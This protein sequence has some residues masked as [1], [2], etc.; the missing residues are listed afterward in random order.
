[1]LILAI[2]FLAACN[3][4]T[5]DNAAP[6]ES[7]IDESEI[8]SAHS[9]SE[10]IEESKQGNPYLTTEE[11]LEE[12]VNQLDTNLPIWAPATMKIPEENHLSAKTNTTNDSYE[13][14]LYALIEPIPI[15]NEALG[16]QDSFI[17]FGVAEYESKEAAIEYIQSEQDGYL[18]FEGESEEINLGY[19]ITGH[20]QAGTGHAGIRWSIGNWK[21]SSVANGDRIKEAEPIAKEVVEVLE[22][23]TLPAPD[24][25]GTVFINQ[26][27]EEDTLT[28]V[29]WQVGSHV[30][31][32]YSDSLTPDQVLETVAKIGKW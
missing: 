19:N 5:E 16:E 3:S 8:T 15:N 21:L 18:T 22:E 13:V 26:D 14:E 32:V 9:Q 23:V 31:S 7:S 17:L 11:V 2:T 27:Y 25:L 10:E 12:T 29:Y 24:E 4:P 6:T 28:E 20:I 1:M 30:I